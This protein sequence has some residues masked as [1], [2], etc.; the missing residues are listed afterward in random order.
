MQLQNKRILLGVTGG[1]AAYKAAEIIRRLRERGA[2]VRVVMTDAAKEFIT[3]LTLQ[4]VSGHIVANSMFDPQ[5][6][7]G[8]GHIELA[9][10]ADLVLV[11]PATANVI[12]RLTTGMGDELLTTLC[13]ASP[14]PLAIAPAMNMQ[15]YLHA[16]TQSN[17]KVLAE[18]GVHI[19]GPGVG[20][21][22]CG[23]VG[24]GRMLD[25][26]DIV[27][28]VTKFLQP[29]PQ[30]DFSFLITA[31]PTREAIDPVRYISNHS[32]GK[33]GFALAEAAAAI[34]AKVTLVAGP[35]NLPTPKGVKRIDVESALEMQSAVE[36]EVAQHP[37]FIG[38]AAVADYRMAEV[39]PQKMK[40]TEGQEGL[41]LQLI[42]NPDIIAGVAARTDK[43][44]VVGF[45]AETQDVARYA[46]DKL[47]RKG[48]DM[49]AANDVSRA[50]QGFN[51]DQNALTVFWADGQQ[52]LPLASKQ[53]V[54]QQLIS[55]II[56]RYQ[57]ETD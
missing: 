25:P 38:C 11:A 30:T 20:S 54:A 8:M 5:A 28:E 41:S 48:M 52:E 45:A 49:I 14:A 42:K 27:E 56:K 3:P 26:M 9:K 51:A 40:K 6:E 37:I 36:A 43:P 7:A 47:Q 53:Q 2:E 22:A 13:L 16:A 18:R 29:A 15:M 34:G 57:H 46:L 1:I 19:W 32:S 4:A 24:P 33:M 35:V 12:S 55:L 44:F 17:L 23:D 21:Q 39:A 31:G 50:D 10:W